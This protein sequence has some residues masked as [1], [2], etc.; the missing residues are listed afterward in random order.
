M[1]VFRLNLKWSSA[2]LAVSLW[3]GTAPPVW[4]KCW[5]YWKGQHFNS[6]G[7][8][9]T[10]SCCTAVRSLMVQYMCEIPRLDTPTKQ[11]IKFSSAPNL[12]FK[13]VL[14]FPLFHSDQVSGNS[15]TD[16][17]ET[18]LDWQEY[19]SQLQDMTDALPC[20]IHLPVCLWIMDP[21][22][23]APKKNTSHEN[24]VLPQGTTHLIQRPCYRGSPC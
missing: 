15:S 23:R 2:E 1:R 19:F 6:I 21:H 13:L 5:K 8:L 12:T 9:L 3:T 4:R 24:D 7:M 17:A 10:T 18:S 14:S 20:H 16:K 11:L 22:S